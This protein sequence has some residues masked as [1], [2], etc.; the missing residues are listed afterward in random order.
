MEDK[1]TAYMA[2]GW[3]KVD[4]R[5]EAARWVAQPGTSEHE[6]GL[7]VD[8]NDREGDEGI[9]P[10]PRRT[11]PRVRLYPALSHGWRG[12]HRASPMSR[13]TSAM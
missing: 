5:A 11:R 10:W 8:I 13:G 6:L 9:Y 2:D 4:A 7:A 1:A 12:D 3:S